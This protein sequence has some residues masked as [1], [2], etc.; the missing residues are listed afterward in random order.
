MTSSRVKY[1]RGA[2]VGSG[3]QLKACLPGPRVAVFSYTVI[4]LLTV[5]AM[6][7]CTVAR[8]VSVKP[9]F[10]TSRRRSPFG[11]IVTKSRR[12][13]AYFWGESV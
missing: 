5:R 2:I 3:N 8:S 12:S 6:R 9:I 4:G 11:E 1:V 13:P 7:R 10:A